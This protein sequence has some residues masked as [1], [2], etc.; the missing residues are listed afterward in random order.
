M[1]TANKPK[2]VIF[3]LDGVLVDTSESHRQAWFDLAHKQGYEISDEFFRR[4]FGTQNYQIIPMLAGQDLP[5][6]QIDRLAEWKEQ[7]Y[8]ELVRDKLALAEGAV[9]LLD[10]LRN[11]NFLLG[12]GT[13]TPRANLDF[14]LACLDI[15][16]CFDAYVTGE[17]VKNG[18]PAPDTFLAAAEKLG[19]LPKRCVVVE[20]A[21]QGVQAARNA[22]MPVIALTT[23]RKR[24]ELYQADLIVRN[25]AELQAADFANLLEN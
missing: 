8:R 13:S 10:D 23:T 16:D 15:T 14:M 3:D 1:S 11:N 25:L 18:K 7:R 5:A 24:E 2:A 20:D 19:A 4:T 9:T 12:I 17:D 21:V 22:K 6:E